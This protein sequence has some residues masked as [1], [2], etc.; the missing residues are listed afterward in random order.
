[1]ATRTIARMFD[2]YA[3]AS[4]AVRELEA[5]GFSHDDVSLIANRGDDATDGTTTTTETESDAGSGAG[6]GATIGTLIGGGAGLLAGLGALAIPGVGPIVAAGWLVAALTGAGVGAAAGGL[7]G[8]LTGAGLSEEHANVYAEGVRRGGNLVTVRT[9]ES[10]VAEAE[11][12]M[13]RHNAAD[14]DTLGTTYR[15]SGWSP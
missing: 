2:S 10:R 8:G 5:A 1:M 11:A 12:I 14:T 3:D 4:A 13:A 15:E 9:D 7:L 6:T